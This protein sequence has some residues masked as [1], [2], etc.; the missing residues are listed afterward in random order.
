MPRP[1]SS[2]TFLDEKQMSLEATPKITYLCDGGVISTAFVYDT[3]QI[4]NAANNVYVQ[5]STI[6]ASLKAKGSE[7]RYQFKTDGERMQ[8]ILGQLG[9]RPKCSG[10]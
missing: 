5:K 4:Q 3:V 6:D 10:F 1:D 8:Y 9:T 7:N 2:I